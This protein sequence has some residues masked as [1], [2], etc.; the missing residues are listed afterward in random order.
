MSCNPKLPRKRQLFICSVPPSS[1][2]GTRNTMNRY[3]K[4]TR[5]F[6]IIWILYLLLTS[7]KQFALYRLKI[8]STLSLLLCFIVIMVGNATIKLH[9]L[10]FF[11]ILLTFWWCVILS[12]ITHIETSKSGIKTRLNRSVLRNLERRQFSYLFKGT[13]FEKNHKSFSAS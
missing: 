4:N 2:S 13:P 7:N 1:T 6:A 11:V 10:Q 9:T 8:I 12:K 3:V 5:I